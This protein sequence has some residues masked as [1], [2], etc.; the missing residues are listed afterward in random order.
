MGRLGAIY[1]INN[2]NSVGGELEWWSKKVETPSFAETTGKTGGTT[3]HSTS[4]YD[5]EEKDRNISAT[6]NYIHKLDTLGSIWKIILDYTD[7]KVTGDN[8]YESLYTIPGGQ[9]DS[10]YRNNSRSNY[11][12]YTTD[13][14]LDK[15]L[16]NGM[17]YTTGVRYARNEMSNNTFY[18]GQYNDQWHP[19]DRYNYALDYAE[20]ISAIYGTFAFK[21]GK[22]DIL[23]GLRGEYTHTTGK[24]DLDKKYADL[25]PN[26]NLTYSFNAMRTFMLIGQ[27]AR[28]IQRPNFWYLNS[29]RIQYSDYSYYVGNPLLRPTYINRMSLTAVYKYRYTFTIGGNLHKD[30]IR[31][32]SK[33]DPKD[34]DVKY[35]TPENHYMENHYFVAISSPFNFT[36]WF[37][38]NNNFVGVKQ[39]IRGVKADKTMSHYLYF[40]NSTANFTLPAEFFFEVSYSGT[41]R[42][43][44]A[45]SGIEPS[46]LFHA[47]IKK[48]LFDNKINLTLGIH[49]IFD[50]R[51]SY[52][53]NMEDY[54][55]SSKGVEAWNSR[56]V[57]L[58]VQYSFNSGKVFKKR[59][60]ESGLNT[61]KERMEKAKQ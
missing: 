29:N 1:E 45:N 54:K 7:K 20:N 5:Q 25:F 42:L 56:S 57:K 34:P 52:F 17:K 11:G 14:M 60:I 31:E 22:L 10:I 35:I 26:L 41:S 40:I 19:L 32:V 46:H 50:H 9:L 44:S 37:S 3:I 36:E 15:R 33:V 23:A 21:L 55:S 53:S 6:F 39:D 16:Q 13:L 47:Q 8:A 59:S 58:S 61:E 49:N 43:Y 4:N 27:Y 28:N 18:E 48:K 24:D 30:L 51:A 38:M 12:I 2:R